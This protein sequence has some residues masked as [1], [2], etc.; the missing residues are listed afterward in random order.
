MDDMLGA[1]LDLSASVEVILD[2][3]GQNGGWDNNALYVTGDH[4]HYL[5]LLNHF[6]EALANFLIAGESYNITPKNNSSLDPWR[7]AILAG[8]HLDDSKSKT[9]HLKD[10]ST[11]SEEDIQNVGHFWGPAGSGGNGWSWHTTRPV[12]LS[13][14]GD[15]GCIDSL[16][17]SGFQVIGHQVQGNENKIDQVHLHACMAKNLFG[18]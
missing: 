7:L 1:I 4:D 9:E 16:T 13:Y 11:W 5:T 17:G 12:P 8:R 6:P 15:N 2:W 3:I 14:M 18:L 10:F